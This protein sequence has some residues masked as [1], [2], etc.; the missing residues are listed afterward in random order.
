M[1]KLDKKEKAL[2]SFFEVWIEPFRIY[3]GGP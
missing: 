1:N 2:I 3:D